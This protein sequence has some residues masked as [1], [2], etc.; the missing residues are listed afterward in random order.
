MKNLRRIHDLTHPLANGS[1]CYPGDPAFVVAQFCTIAQDSFSVHRIE[2]GTHQG[3]HV[4]APSHF[5]E[6]GASIDAVAL[7]KF[8][9]DAV[10]LRIP[11]NA[12]ETIGLEDFAPFAG[13][14]AEDARVIIATGWSAKWNTPEFFENPPRIAIEAARYL[15]D[16]KIALIG[17][18]TPTPGFPE[19][20]IHDVLLKADVAILENL[21][22]PGDCPDAF[23]LF[24]APLRLVGCDGSPVRALA[25]ISADRSDR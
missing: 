20:A 21:A 24:A 5:L 10:L 23:T 25:I 7:E 18:D 6:G 17:T 11:K 15:A 16:C 12:G 14:I 4:D 9:G 1:P 8:V 13:K 19:R 3:T 22:I 2:T